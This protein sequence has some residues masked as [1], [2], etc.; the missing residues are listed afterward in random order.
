[1]KKVLLIGATAVVVGGLLY[2]PT[3]RAPKAHEIIEQQLVH[4]NAKLAAQNLGEL[5]VQ[6][7]E[8]DKDGSHV[9]LEVELAI[10]QEYRTSETPESI[11]LTS[12]LDI[13]FGFLP[14]IKGF[15][16]I[17]STTTSPDINGALAEIGNLDGLT[18]TCDTT[19]ESKGYEAQCSTNAL[20]LKNNKA[21]PAGQ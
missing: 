6:K 2:Y 17:H 13:D 11:V 5:K 8:T 15:K 4:M 12:I 16:S 9:E 21:Q 14:T 1:M 7:H 20:T 19:P 3:Y 18:L 10:P